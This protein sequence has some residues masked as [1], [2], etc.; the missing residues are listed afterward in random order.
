MRA[1]MLGFAVEDSLALVRLDDLYLETFEI[2]DGKILGSDT[3]RATTFGF[4]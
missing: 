1:F 3:S 2:Q 4:F